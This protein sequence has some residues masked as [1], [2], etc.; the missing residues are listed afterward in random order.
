MPENLPQLFMR[1]SDMENIPETV[2]PDGITLHTHADGNE[3]EW[4]NL[5]ENSFGSHF[6]FA[7]SLTNRKGYKPEHVFYLSRDGIDVATASAIE[8]QEFPNEGWL[9]MVGVHTSARGLGLSKPI[10]TAALDSFAKRGFKSVM[11]STDDFRIPAIK[12]YLS[13]G[14]HPV[15]SHESHASRWD[16]VMSKIRV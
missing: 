3:K 8:K 6:D 4:E 14:F 11:L 9:H 10:V 12:T 15:L 2:L 16:E 13:L 7:N 5:I 1:K